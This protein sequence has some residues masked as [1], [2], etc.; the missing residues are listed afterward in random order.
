M[1]MNI[2]KYLLFIIIP[3]VSVL[4]CVTFELAQGE[5]IEEIIFGIMSGIV[6]DL[7]YLIVLLLMN[8]KSVYNKNK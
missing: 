6:L 1:K 3:A 7:I 5:R 8:K 4:L 2:L